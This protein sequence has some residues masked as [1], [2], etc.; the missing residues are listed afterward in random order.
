LFKMFCISFDISVAPSSGGPAIIVNVAFE[1]DIEVIAEYLGKRTLRLLPEP[2]FAERVRDLVASNPNAFE[3]CE[4][5]VGGTYFVKNRDGTRVGVFKPDDEEPGASRN[6]KQLVTEPI[7]P[8]GGGAIRET[9]A[10]LLDKGRT[11]VPETVMLKDL[12]HSLWASGKTGSLQEYVSHKTV[13]ADMGSSLFS[14]DNVHNI[15]ILDMRLL[16][17]DRNGENLLVVD[18]GNQH[19]RLVPIDHAY[20]LPP[21]IMNPVFEWHFWKQS[22]VPFSAETLKFIDE[23]DVEEDAKVLREAGIPEECIRTMKVSTILLKKGAAHN[24]TLFQISSLFCAE[25]KSSELA[26]VVDKT[27]SLC[28]GEKMFFPVFEQLVVELICRKFPL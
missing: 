3:L 20:I 13:A 21:K 18:D 23:I 8:P 22:K 15:G 6:P 28:S 14:V 17:L 2:A 5:G 24:L 4:Q 16:N 12:N 7:L 25:D 26:L 1:I 11:G 9:V 19:L 10:Y 27:E